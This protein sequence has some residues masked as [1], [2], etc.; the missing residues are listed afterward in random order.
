MLKPSTNLAP[1]SASARERASSSAPVV[2]TSSSRKIR[3]LSTRP[4]FPHCKS[5]TYRFNGS[6]AAQPGLRS[7][8]RPA[9]DSEDEGR[10]RSPQI[11]LTPALGQERNA[12][13]CPGGLPR[14]SPQKEDRALSEARG[15]VACRT[16][17]RG[18]PILE[19]EIKNGSRRRAQTGGDVR[20]PVSYPIPN[21][22]MDSFSLGRQMSPCSIFSWQPMQCF[23]HGTASRRFCC[24]SS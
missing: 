20:Q 10:R 24:I 7:A 2:I 14:V 11:V 1:A 8:G 19:A 6:A 5:A 9:A 16:L 4:A 23:A 22:R 12:L 21:D 3:K 17:S 18:R 15:S 13:A